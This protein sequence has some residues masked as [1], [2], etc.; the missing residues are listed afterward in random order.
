MYITAE[1]SVGFR[2]NT[3]YYFYTFTRDAPAASGPVSTSS[4]PSAPAPAARPATPSVTPPPTQADAGLVGTWNVTFNGWPG[5]ME[6][7]ERGGAYQGRFN[8]GGSGWEVMLDLRIELSAISFRRT[9][10]DQRYVGAIAGGVIRGTFS[11]GG[12]GSYAWTATK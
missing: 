12:A 2:R 3:F 10:G 11:Q 1:W 5:S 8:L 9:Q 4:V 7:T 6:I